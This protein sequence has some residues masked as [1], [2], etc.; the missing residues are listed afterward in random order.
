MRR[1]TYVLMA[2]VLVTLMAAPGASAK[3]PQ[4]TV[5]GSLNLKGTTVPDPCI[6]GNSLRATG[7]SVRLSADI[8]SADGTGEG[9]GVIFTGTLVARATGLTVTDPVSGT[10]YTGEGEAQIELGDLRVLPVKI[11]SLRSRLALSSY[12]SDSEGL[13]PE[14]AQKLGSAGALT[15][16]DIEVS[17]TGITAHLSSIRLACPLSDSGGAAPGGLPPAVEPGQTPTTEPGQTPTREPEG[18]PTGEP[19]QKATPEP[20][21]TPTRELGQESNPRPTPDAAANN[22]TEMS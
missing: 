4:L 1:L 3:A 22:R 19:E 12:T 10:V 5:R 18:T 15:L 14:R 6:K 9:Q 11:P 7:G 21:Q 8:R 20:E 17:A 13:D 16:T 2:V